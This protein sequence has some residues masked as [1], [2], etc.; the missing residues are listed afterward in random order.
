MPV[1]THWRN[2]FTPH[3]LMTCTTHKVTQ[4][5]PTWNSWSGKM[6]QMGGC[7]EGQRQP[8]SLWT[9]LCGVQL[10]KALGLHNL[11]PLT[12]QSCSVAHSF[13]ARFNHKME[14]ANRNNWVGFQD[15]KSFDTVKACFVAVVNLTHQPHYHFQSKWHDKGNDLISAM[16]WGI[17]VTSACLARRR[18]HK[19]GCEV[20]T[21]THTHARVIMS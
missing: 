1:T 17:L 16:S 8:H 6:R 2:G 4:L 5:T 21:H 15:M 20:H 12:L 14:M 13:P 11:W 9:R 19:W 10:T 18:W 7:G 3:H